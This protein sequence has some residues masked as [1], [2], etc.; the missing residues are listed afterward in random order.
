MALRSGKCCPW[1]GCW[2]RQRWRT[3][4]R[5]LSVR[6]KP[7][8]R[9]WSNCRPVTRN[10]V[11]WSGRQVVRTPARPHWTRSRRPCSWSESM[12][13]WSPLPGI[14]PGRVGTAHIGVLT[15]PG[16]RGRG[17]ARV[18]GSATVAHALAAGLLPQW[19]ARPPASRRV[20]AVLGFEELGSQ[21]SV[22]IAG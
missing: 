16:A 14:G 7:V 20:A 18:T 15:A 1:P 9:R 19:R 2:G 17:L 22:E 11:F 13:R 5:R 21:L 8:R 10:C 12:V 3:C 4:L 6:W